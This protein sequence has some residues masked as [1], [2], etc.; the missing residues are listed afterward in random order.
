MPNTPPQSNSLLNLLNPYSSMARS[1][2][3]ARQNEPVSPSTM[4]LRELQGA[5]DGEGSEEEDQDRD[6]RGPAAR[7]RE[8][9]SPTPTP[10]QRRTSAI[11]TTH[12]SSDDED[13]PPQS[14]MYAASGSTPTAAISK[15]QAR[16]ASPGPFKPALSSSASES[17]SRSTSPGPSTISNYASG[18]EATNLEPS[19]A[20]EPVS[21]PVSPVRHVPTF[22]EPVRPSPPVR[23]VSG[24]SSG[25]RKSPMKGYLDPP[26]SSST[27]SRKG[28]VKAKTK[29]A[30]G[31][32]YHEVGRHDEEEDEDDLGGA[33]ARPL[34]KQGLNEYE[35][36]L[37]KWVNVEDLDGFLQEVCQP[38]AAYAES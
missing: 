38:S 9:L 20:P 12:T 29:T 11:A 28:K 14:L 6:A 32:W 16:I 7:L 25:K 8:R 1:T 18:L 19:A 10:S 36:A 4:L 30:G 31:R 26:L 15:G 37:W 24:T 27:T 21:T 33:P 3:P 5:E 2:Y 23:T 13:Q 35:K 22:R 17:R 34:G